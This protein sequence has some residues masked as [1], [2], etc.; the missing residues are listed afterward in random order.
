MFH[1]FSNIHNTV[2]K[3]AC[4]VHTPYLSQLQQICRVTPHVYSHTI[5]DWLI[6]TH[7]FSY[8][9]PYVCT[10]SDY[11]NLYDCIIIYMLLNTV[12]FNFKWRYL[13]SRVICII[14]CDIHEYTYLRYFSDTVQT[15]G[16]ATEARAVAPR[17]LYSQLTTLWLFVSAAVEQGG[18]H[19]N[20]GRSRRPGR[21]VFKQHYLH[22]LQF[23]IFLPFS[24]NLLEDLGFSAKWRF[25]PP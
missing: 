13:L 18:G 14:W 6:T 25:K 9:F 19:S 4:N 3:W 12:V 8:M 21:W 7:M 20:S 24:L 15:G 2:N 16:T 17:T 23:Y 22:C 5:H 1:A 11:T 10:Y